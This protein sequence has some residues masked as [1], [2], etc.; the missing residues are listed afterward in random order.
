MSRPGT[1]LSAGLAMLAVAAGIVTCLSF[2]NAIAQGRG[3]DRND[4]G[5]YD[6]DRG[7]GHEQRR[8]QSR[9]HDWQRE[10]WRNNY[11]GNWREPMR[12]PDIY[13]SAP[14]VFHVPPRYYQPPPPG[15]S[16]QFGFPLYY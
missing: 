15:L 8:Q 12:R 13:Y 6:N 5:R 3:N 16:L 4:N 1:R 7:R 11:G 14:P 10:H 2:G 9:H